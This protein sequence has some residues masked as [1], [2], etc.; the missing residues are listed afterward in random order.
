LKATTKNR[1]PAA[2]RVP[3]KASPPK[4]A[5]FDTTFIKGMS[6]LELMSQSDRPLGVTELAKLAQLQNSNVHRILRT[7]IKMG[8]VH[9]NEQTSRYQLNLK[10]WEVAARVM[11]RNP[12][13]RV[14]RPFVRRLNEETKEAAFLALRIGDEMLYI[15]CVDAMFPL[16]PTVRPGARAPMAFTA[17]GKAILAFSPDGDAWARRLVAENTTGRP[18]DAKTLMAQLSDVRRNGY[19]YTGKGWTSGISTVAAPIVTQ[20][21]EVFAAIGIS[22]PSERFDERKVSELSRLVLNAA[23]GISETFVTTIEGQV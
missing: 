9:K 14:S 13:R 18:L 23:T 2:A 7:L 1:K 16:R 10:I 8:Y 15:D 19:A 4:Q 22:V 12:L 17:S 5:G 21:A 11:D 6:V 3:P 20:S